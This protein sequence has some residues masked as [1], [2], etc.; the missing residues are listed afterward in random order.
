MNILYYCEK[1]NK[2]VYIKYGSSRFCSKQCS[3][4]HTQTDEQNKRRSEK[5]SKLVTLKC[6]ICG[7][8]F[9]RHSWKPKQTCSK[10]CLNKLHTINGKNCHSG[11][12][13]IN[14]GRSKCGY[15]K[16]IYCGSTYELA[17]LVY[18]IDNNIKIERNFDYFTY[19]YDG[20]VHKYYPDFKINNR[21]Y[22]E[23]KGIYSN[24]VEIKL[25]CVYAPI[26]L[27][28]KDDLKVCFNHLVNKYG[29]HYN[30]ANNNFYLLYDKYM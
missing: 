11:G 18:C 29:L 14:S 7:K 4:S 27:L 28:L 17:F 3:S 26:K 30:K 16:G 13:R 19:D 20:K 5:L 8:E 25:N 9:T 12:D 10:E 21:T 22:I 23:V 1:C 6:V 15:Y 24:L 2:P